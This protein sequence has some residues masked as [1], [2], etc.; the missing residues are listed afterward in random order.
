MMRI[1]IFGP[2]GSGKGTYSSRISEE[3][4]IP[5]ISTG[6]IVRGEIEK[7]STLGRRME[8]YSKKGDLVPNSVVIDIL[9]RRMQRPDCKNGFILDGYPRTLAQDEALERITPIDLVFYLD[10]PEQVSVE[11]LLSRLVCQRCGAIYNDRF[12]RPRISGI[13]D[14]CGGRLFKRH[15]DKPEVILKRLKIFN[16]QAKPLLDHYK[17]RGLLRTV[18]VN[19]NQTS[20][21]TVVDAILSTLK[22]ESMSSG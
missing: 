9:R 1:L 7:N 20:P 6:D 4:A 10:V 2:P 17:R 19:D 15:D 3:F 12:L 8:G 16:E 11:R 18:V 22:G 13:C 14:K 5:H 21:E